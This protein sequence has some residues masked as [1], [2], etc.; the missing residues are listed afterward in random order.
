MTTETPLKPCPPNAVII[1]NATL[2]CGDC[3]DVFHMLNKV[4]CVI[5]D[6]PYGLGEVR[7]T[8]SKARQRNSYSIY[9]D[10]EQCLIE[11]IIPRFQSA[12]SLSS[13]R[14]LVTPGAK[15]LQLWPRAVTIGGFY[16]P[17]AVGMTPWGFA[18]FN[19]VLF[20]GKDQKAGRGQ[21]S[22]ATT[23]TERPS[24]NLHPC[25]KPLGAMKWMV[26]KCTIEGQVVLDPFMGSGTTGV[27]A[28][29][30]GR[31]FIGIE[32]DPDYFAIACKRIE[33]AQRQGDIFNTRAG[34]TP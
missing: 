27:A 29:Q 17:A 26:E 14:G 16:Q 24:T 34:E 8:T 1:G 31:K 4:D 32:L 21:S 5:T 9:D 25:A 6:P 22:T 28:V 19:P 23:L 18:G 33:D 7:G 3:A 10:T 30:M 15:C 11:N 13:G 12:L 20:Y 2:Y